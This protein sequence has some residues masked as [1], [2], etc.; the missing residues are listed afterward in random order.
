MFRMGA[1]VELV[2]RIVADMHAHGLE[3]DAKET[4]LLALAEGLANGLADLEETV[5]YEGLSVVLNSRRIVMNPAV[6]ESRMTRTA[7]ATVL[8]RVS[9]EDGRAKDPLKVK[10]AQVRW[11]A[12]NLAKAQHSG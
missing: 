3:P 10:A 2:A 7:L 4:E 8:G 1:G 6:T 11:A 12:H 9:M 5:E